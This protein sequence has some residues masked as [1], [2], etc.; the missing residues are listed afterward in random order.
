MI[1]LVIFEYKSFPKDGKI[2]YLVL[3]VENLLP[4]EIEP[5]RTIELLVSALIRPSGFLLK[6]RVAQLL[7]HCEP[8]ANAVISYLAVNTVLESR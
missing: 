1:V 7:Q 2:F 6:F 5:C 8:A 3:Q 4:K